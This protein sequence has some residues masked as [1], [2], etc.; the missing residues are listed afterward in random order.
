MFA[1]S[2]EFIAGIRKAIMGEAEAIA[3][4]R[5]LQ[6]MVRGEDRRIIGGIIEDEERHYRSFYSLYQSLAG[7]R[8]E[9]EQV[10]PPQIRSLEEGLR[11]AVIDEVEAADF[12]SELYVATQDGTIRDLLFGI[13]QDEQGHAAL[14]N[15]LYTKHSHRQR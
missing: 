9:L 15:L 14:F 4:Y 10:S 3:F 5:A 6:Q 11:M 7:K 2:N 1:C 8:P 13:I 12:Y